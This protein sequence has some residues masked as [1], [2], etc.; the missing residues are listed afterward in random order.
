M[1]E[2]TGKRKARPYEGTVTVHHNGKAYFVALYTS[3][4]MLRRSLILMRV[5][6]TGRLY[7]TD[8]PNNP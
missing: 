2:S 8:D 1:R 7:T 4:K 6:N 5:K 3:P